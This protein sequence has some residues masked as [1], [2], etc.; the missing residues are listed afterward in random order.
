MRMDQGLPPCR[1]SLDCP[2]LITFPTIRRA[3]ATKCRRSLG[4][5]KMITV[6]AARGALP[7]AIS[8]PKTDL[9]DT[10]LLPPS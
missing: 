9:S 7:A 3:W 1:R 10:S 4:C 5:T 8:F 6:P 2:K